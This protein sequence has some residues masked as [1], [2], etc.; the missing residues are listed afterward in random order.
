MDL[1]ELECLSSTDICPAVGLLDPTVA[2]LV[3]SKILLCLLLIPFCIPKLPPGITFLCL[4]N[5]SLFFF[6]WCVC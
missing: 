6:H 5:N 1:F 2:L 4:D 3:V